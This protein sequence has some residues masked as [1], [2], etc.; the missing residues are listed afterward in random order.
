MGTK[1]TVKAMTPEMLESLGAVIVLAGNTYPLY[2]QPGS[3][4]VAQAGDFQNL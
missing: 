4:L 1:A 2:L 3:D